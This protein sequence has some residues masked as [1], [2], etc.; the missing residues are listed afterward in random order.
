MTANYA[1]FLLDDFE[2]RDDLQD[3]SLTNA[4]TGTTISGIKAKNR[5]LNYRETTLGGNLGYEPTDQVFA[6]GCKR[7]GTAV[8]NRGDT[9][10]CADGTKWTIL[11][12]V[13][14]SFGDT[15]V[16]Y[17]VVCRRQV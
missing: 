6:V 10:T 11:S 4:V 16:L 8:P 7:L 14:N 13:M 12:D 2:L 15:P 1:N 3:V 17:E 5:N 9:I